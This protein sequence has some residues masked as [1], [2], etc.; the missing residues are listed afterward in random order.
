[1]ITKSSKDIDMNTL[2]YCMLAYGDTDSGKSASGL[3]LPGPI[4]ICN[5]EDKD[6]RTVHSQFITDKEVS[7]NYPES[8]D[9]FMDNINIW[10]EEAKAGK[11]IY[12]SLFL[13]GLTF[14]QS[15]FKHELEDDRYDARLVES[16]EL[17]S[18]KVERRGLTDRFRFEKPD[19]GSIG[20]MM[21]RL[22]GMLNQ[23]VKFGVIVVATAQASHDYPKYGGGVQT[24][25]S[26]IGFDY[27]KL[28]HGFFDYIGYI[29]KPF[30]LD[31]KMV[32]GKPVIVNGQ[33]VIIPSPPRI[34]FH[35]NLKQSADDT[36]E[37]GLANTSQPSYMARS[38][39][40]DLV[41]RGPA[42][43]NYELITKV[44]RKAQKIP[45]A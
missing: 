33:P 11:F 13:D 25:P 7:Y 28:I 44:I 18:N 22:T 3:T 2:A 36:D 23:F 40:L 26:L 39:C 43:L 1:M 41:R 38:S 42:P 19:W 27:S 24:A 4:K 16:E 9:D 15:R 5:T 32:D 14:T 45:L 21:S 12:K 6:I 37:F 29:I 17:R 34:S 35:C 30:S 31:T 10:L 20:S 8:F